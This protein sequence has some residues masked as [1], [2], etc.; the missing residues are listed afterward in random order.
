MRRETLSAIAD[1]RL[2][3]ERISSAVA[4]VEDER[5]LADWMIQSAVER[6]LLVVGEAMV[7]IRD[8]DPGVFN[9]IPDGLRIISLRNLLAH[10]Y[11][12]V[13]AKTLL[14]LAREKLPKLDSI[15]GNLLLG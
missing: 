6:Q 7:R 15:L 14:R 1:I 13:D 2:A 9:Q 12:A 5:Y 10:G 8:L 11:D 4:N 3:I